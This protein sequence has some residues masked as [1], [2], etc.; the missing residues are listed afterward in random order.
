MNITEQ[1]S[2]FK[3]QDWLER[4]LKTNSSKLSWT[5]ESR[6]SPDGWTFSRIAVENRKPLNRRE[7]PAW[8]AITTNEWVGPFQ[9]ADELEIHFKTCC[10]LEEMF[11]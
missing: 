3:S 6:A 9:A 5:D 4:T 1:E 2:Q 7:V 8:A 10:H 11:S